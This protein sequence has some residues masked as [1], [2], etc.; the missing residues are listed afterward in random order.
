MLKY[1]LITRYEEFI[2]L[3]VQIR[4]DLSYSV[5]KVAQFMSNPCKKHWTALKR[6]LRYLQEIRELGVCY[7][8]SE[9]KLALPLPALML[10]G[11]R[12]SIIAIQLKATYTHAR[13]T[14]CMEVSKN[15]FCRSFKY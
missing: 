12:I 5:S 13:G 8:R 9:R 10:V 14:G 1:K 2:Y 4:P 3:I 11:K 7:S 15:T 6:V